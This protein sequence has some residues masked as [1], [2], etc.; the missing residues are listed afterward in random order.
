METLGIEKGDILIARKLGKK[1]ILEPKGRGILDMAGKFG[2][3]DIPKGKT[4]GDL[5]EEAVTY[6]EKDLLS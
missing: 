5:I 4:V 1:V 3:L 6:D 2:K